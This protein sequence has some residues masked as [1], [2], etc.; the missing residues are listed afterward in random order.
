MVQRE[1]KQT[2]LS[3]PNVSGWID[4]RDWIVF[5]TLP[6]RLKL[7]QRMLARKTHVRKKTP[8]QT[9]EGNEDILKSKEKLLRIKH[10]LQP[11]KALTLMPTKNGYKVCKRLSR[12]LFTCDTDHLEPIFK[13]YGS[14][15]NQKKMNFKQLLSVFTTFPEYQIH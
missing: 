8:D 9:N 11:I 1:L 12:M 10:D 7:G 6:E 15:F 13:L 2:L 4:G 14:A 3:P 5:C